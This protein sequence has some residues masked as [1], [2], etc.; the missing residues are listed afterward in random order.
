MRED[1][2]NKDVAFIDRYNS[3]KQVLTGGEQRYISA[4]GRDLGAWGEPMKS[5]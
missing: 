2:T 4:D 3:V 1:L 5:L